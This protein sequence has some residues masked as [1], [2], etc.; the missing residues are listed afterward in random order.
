MAE[1][2]K[3]FAA[4][5]ELGTDISDISI[6]TPPKDLTNSPKPIPAESGPYQGEQKS[7]VPSGNLGKGFFIIAAVIG[8]I[9]VL[10]D[11]GNKPHTS[12][13]YSAPS[14]TPTVYTPAPQIESAPPIGRDIVLN[15]DQIRYCLSEGIRLDSS[16]GVVNDHDKYAIDRFNAL[17]NDYNSRCGSFRYNENVFRTVKNEVETNRW[18]LQ[19]DGISRFSR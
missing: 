1:E 14:T 5:G 19:I 11:S 7:A 3:G 13:S 17:V 8:G 10:S 4:L 6:E 9:W 15:R 16:R 2:K 18:S 12:S